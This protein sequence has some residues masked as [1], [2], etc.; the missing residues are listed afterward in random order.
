MVEAYARSLPMSGDDLASISFREHFTGELRPT[1]RGSVPHDVEAGEQRGVEE[2]LH[3]IK[4]Q[5][6]H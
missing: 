3:Q 1:P 6:D 4:T 5:T 2:T